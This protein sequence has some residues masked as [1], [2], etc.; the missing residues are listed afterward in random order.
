MRKWWSSA[1]ISAAGDFMRR[2]MSE[3]ATGFVMAAILLF[4]GI[5]LVSVDDVL[6]ASARLAEQPTE[7]A[8]SRRIP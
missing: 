5:R 1:L 2:W 6:G 8:P 7:T 4:A 3:R